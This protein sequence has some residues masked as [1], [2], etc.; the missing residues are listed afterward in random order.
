MCCFSRPIQSV[1]A[2]NIFARRAEDGRQFLAYSMT[3]TARED[4]AMVLPL[5]VEAGS[6]EKA[7]TFI[8]LKNYAAFFSDLRNGFPMP[9]SLSPR[10]ASRGD[11]P[12]KLKLEV[13]QVGSFDASYVPTV[14]DFSRLDAR[15]RL[16]PG[17]WDNLPAYR[18]YGFAVF[19]L[20]PGSATIHPMAFSFPGAD[21]S[22]LFFPT[23]HIHDGK[24]H[25]IAK[26]D[27]E[28][29]CQTGPEERLALTAWIESAR[30]ANAF[31]KTGDAK[32]LVDGERHCYMTVLRGDL[33]NRDT[34]LRQL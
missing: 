21:R 13:V 34:V 32:G 20:K 9:H 18:A 15:F 26:F 30:P 14:N 23:V 19:K 16:P 25:A 6:G 3:L 2:T 11:A 10:F 33:P 24:V 12:A 5:P 29:Y 27:H 28:L 1:S 4:L 8:D 31:M 17:T 22:S 7:V